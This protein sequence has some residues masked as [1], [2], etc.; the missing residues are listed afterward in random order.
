MTQGVTRFRNSWTFREGNVAATVVQG[1]IANVNMVNWTVDV[2]TQFDQKHYFDIQV[3][4][5]YVHPNNGEGCYTL[6]EVGAKCMVCIPSDS[7]PPFVMSFVMPLE[8]TDM[9]APDAP[10][11]TTSQSSPGASASGA[12]F[13]G[14]RPRTKPG[15]IFFRTRDDN[16]VILHRGGILQ[17]GANELAQRIYL[18]M[19][20]QIMDVSQN[21]SHHNA[22][23]S[24]HWSIGEG[25]T[26]NQPTQYG[27]TFRVYANSEFADVR[28][29][30]GRVSAMKEPPGADG[31][32]AEIDAE[33]LGAGDDLILY[34]VVVAKDGFSAATGDQATASVPKESVFRFFFDR[35]GGAFLRCKASLVVSTKK[36]LTVRALAG[37]DIQ[38]EGQFVAKAAGGMVLDGGSFLQL[39]AGVIRAGNSPVMHV[40]SL[41]QVTLPFTPMPAP[42]P[43]VPLVLTGIGLTGDPR[44]TVGP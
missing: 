7:S 11:G 4:S 42:G 37:I 38:T 39:K 3:G 43:P 6:P 24:I 26:E 41:V 35:A 44:F 23:G 22:G 21:Y 18:P 30:C 19:Q 25:P 34:E 28:V 13:A 36:K 16:F 31:N 20:S 14:G 15:D 40:G 2:T 29:R 8:V 1:R 5:M 17:L 32:Q 10:G 9:A 27:Q 12:S 33:G